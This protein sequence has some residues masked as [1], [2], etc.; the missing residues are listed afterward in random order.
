MA[1]ETVTAQD[2]GGLNQALNEATWIG[3]S[4]DTAARRAG[5]LLD[6]LSLPP[7]GL[8][9]PENLVVLML[10][11]VTRIAASLRDGCWNDTEAAAA[12]LRVEDLDATVRSFGG[13]PVYGWEFF[14]PPEDSWS[15][16]RHR[17]SIDARFQLRSCSIF[18][19]CVRSWLKTLVGM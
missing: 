10:G 11:Q 18:S 15:A 3:F 16:W 14:D 17:L 4:I 7:E 2:I 1:W 5:L 13:C 19:R 6:V 8:A 12:P 9:A